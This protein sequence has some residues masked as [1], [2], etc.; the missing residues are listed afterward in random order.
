MTTRKGFILRERQTGETGKFIDVLTAEDGVLELYVRGARKAASKSGSVTQ[1]YAYSTLSFEERKGMLYFQSGEPIHIFY[2]LRSQL[3]HFSLAAYFAELICYSVPQQRQ[4][5]QILRLLL[6]TLYQLTKPNAD[7]NLLKSI[8]EL[9]LLAEL[10]LMPDI[11]L[12]RTC[13]AFEPEQL[14]FSVREGCFWCADCYP[15]DA[16]DEL[17]VS[18]PK[19]VLQAIRHILLS[20]FQR[21]YQFRLRPAVQQ[22]LFQ[23]AE[24][25]IRYHLDAP[26][27][28]L[29]FYHTSL[30][31]ALP[32]EEPDSQ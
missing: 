30:Q 22:P 18:M 6:N 24:R 1:L 29:S 9:R 17:A 21:L 12:C 25:S 2:A 23:F 16:S 13:N 10:G 7:P 15:K 8:F 3:S 28:T 19:G 4:D 26:L 14:V 5:N 20:D 11:L 27:K 31:S 32:A